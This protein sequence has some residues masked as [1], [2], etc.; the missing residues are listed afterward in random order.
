MISVCLSHALPGVILSALL[1]NLKTKQILPASEVFLDMMLLESSH[2]LALSSI[3]DWLFSSITKT[4]D[5]A[6]SF[7]SSEC[8]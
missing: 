4:L 1:P 2:C 8:N 5:L 7:E 3:V 6:I